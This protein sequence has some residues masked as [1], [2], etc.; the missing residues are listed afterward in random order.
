[1]VKQAFRQ[2]PSPI[3][4]AEYLPIAVLIFIL[5]QHKSTAHELEVIYKIFPL[6]L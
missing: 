1:M 3:C 6:I 4:E 5:K 2:K